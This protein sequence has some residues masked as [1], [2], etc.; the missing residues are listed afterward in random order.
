MPAGRRPTPTKLKVLHGNPGRR[1]LNRAEPDPEPALPDCPAELPEAARSEWRRVA[2]EL[3]GLGLLSRIDRAALA[4]YCEAW[5]QWLEAIAAVRRSG[6]V[7]KAP[8]GYA[9]LNPHLAVANQAY[10]RMKAM[11]V[12]F[13]MTP[14][15]R[16]RIVAA[17]APGFEEDPAL[18]DFFDDPPPRWL[19]R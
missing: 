15:S 13:G 18:A 6:A 17:A 4:A 11:L 14:A 5:G 16:S 8:S 9:I 19:R 12:E 7:V 3:H 1:P 2:G 10:G